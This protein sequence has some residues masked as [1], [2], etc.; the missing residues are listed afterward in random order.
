M[1]SKSVLFLV[2]FLLLF[3]III[4]NWAFFLSKWGIDLTDSG[5]FLYTQMRILN[6]KMTDI[7][8]TFLWIG[9]DWIGSFWLSFSKYPDLQF[10]RLGSFV[11]YGIVAIIVC[12]T[13]FELT[14]DKKLSIIITLISYL[15]F[16]SLN[17]FSIIDYDSAP[18]L[19]LSILFYLIVKFQNRHSNSSILFF[20]GS[21]TLFLILTRFTLFPMLLGYLIV[22]FY[23]QKNINFKQSLIFLFAILFT[24]L[25]LFSFD[26]TRNNILLTYNSIKTAILSLISND[27]QV[28]AFSI[29]NSNNYSLLDQ[30]YF[31]IRG[32]SRFAVIIVIIILYLYLNIKYSKVAKFNLI[33]FVSLISF[34]FYPFNRYSELQNHIYNLQDQL[35]YN[36]ILPSFVIFL[37][38]LLIKI[39]SKH[40]LIL[41]L[42]FLT[43]IFYPLGSNSFEKKMPLTFPILIPILFTL[44][45]NTDFVHLTVLKKSIYKLF[46]TFIF[47]LIISNIFKINKFPYR[48]LHINELTSKF[49]IQ[50]LKNIRTTQTKKSSIE[51]VLEYLN[52]NSTKEST[53]LCVGNSSIINY[54][55]NINGISDYPNISYA[56]TNFVKI[57]FSKLSNSNRLPNLI[58]YPS[59]DLRFSDWEIRKSQIIDET[60][61]YLFIEKFIKKN[62]YELVFD[63]DYFKIYSL[64]NFL[65]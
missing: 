23:F 34:I 40:K 42:L 39:D 36:Y 14:S 9:S 33:L 21:S 56:D 35:I 44:F 41:S 64:N 54:L 16:C 58:V 7:S 26:L 48:D 55:T 22:I 43:L 51:P 28:T 45:Q 12:F 2:G 29:F 37:I 32:Y 20:I 53:L 1:K 17:I 5:F 31:W 27:K 25:I 30:L 47:I 65:N 61:F 38:I 63:N 24:L 18:L 15:S 19:P 10:A 52:K 4:V 50:S 49:K 46:I 3:F 57:N 13:I 62:N 11:L 8:P 59:Y 6:S 60:G